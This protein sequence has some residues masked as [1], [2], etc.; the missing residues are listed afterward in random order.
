MHDHER[1]DFDVLYSRA[2][3]LAVL[4][5]VR[6]FAPGTNISAACV[7]RWRK[8]GLRWVFQGP[9]GFHWHGTADNEHE[10]SY[11][12]WIAWL[13]TQGWQGAMHET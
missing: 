5:E 1:P 3:H 6:K 2:L 10:A 11:R 7:W 13:E 8:C 12:G 4:D 9:G